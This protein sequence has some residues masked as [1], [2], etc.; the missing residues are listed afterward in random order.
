MT[1]Y[2]NDEKKLENAMA[3]ALNSFEI[4]DIKPNDSNIILKQ[5]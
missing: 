4:S 5:L 3:L 2:S 1:L